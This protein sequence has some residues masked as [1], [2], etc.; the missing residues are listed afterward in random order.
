MSEKIKFKGRELVG[1][2]VVSSE[3]EESLGRIRDLLLDTEKGIIKAVILDGGNWLREPQLIAFE[4][5][6]LQGAKAFSVTDESVISKKL[7]AK[8]KCWQENKGLSL[9]NSEGT[10]LGL[11]EDIVIDWPSGRISALE[12]SAGLVNDLMDGRKEVTPI[13]KVNWTLD[14]V[15]IS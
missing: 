5:L 9:L 10:E 15:I 8:A 13:G 3:K 7:S 4:K 6:K 11:V 12:V 14:K 2:P 1:L